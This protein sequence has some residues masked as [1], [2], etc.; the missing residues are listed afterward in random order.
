MS[1]PCAWCGGEATVGIGE[2]GGLCDSCFDELLGEQRALVDEL[3]LEVVSDLYAPGA[4]T[5]EPE[6][7]R[8][9]EVIRSPLLCS[10][11]G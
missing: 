7:I 3:V 1:R 10:E 11:D 9:V 4:R 6:R 8:R 5:F 2:L